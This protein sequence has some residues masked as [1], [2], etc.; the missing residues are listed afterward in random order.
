VD[1]STKIPGVTSG[2][3]PM[4]ASLPVT[5]ASNQTPVPTSML[6]YYYSVAG[7]MFYASS[8]Y[9]TTGAAAERPMMLV[10]NPVASGISLIFD[11]CMLNP[12]GSGSCIYRT[13]LNATVT[14]NGTVVTAV[15]GRQTGQAAAVGL[16]TTI[17]TVTAN[18]SL[19][20]STRIINTADCITMNYDFGF[21]LEPGN[22]L[23]FTVEKSGAGVDTSV[24]LAY[25]EVATP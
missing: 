20:D 25:A 1:V 22:N 15:G 19:I 5:I 3:A 14:V 7:K 12:P 23:L 18:G 16:I 4:A 13:Y 2:Q 11:A 6:N 21:I 9:V 8:N 10:R 24:D 17:P